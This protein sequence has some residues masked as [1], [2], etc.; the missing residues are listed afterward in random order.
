MVNNDSL[1]STK[2][3]AEGL[4]LHRVQGSGSNAKFIAMNVYF[5]SLYQAL[6]SLYP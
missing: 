5:C 1:G 2:K 3:V 6:N 4:H